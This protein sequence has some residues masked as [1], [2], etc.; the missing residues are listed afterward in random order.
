MELRYGGSASA[1]RPFRTIETLLP[2]GAGKRGRGNRLFLNA[3]FWI[4]R[5]GAPWRD[6]PPDYGDWKHRPAGGETAVSGT[7]CVGC[8]SRK[9]T[10][11]LLMVDASHIKVPRTGARGGNQIGRTKCKLS[12]S[13]QPGSGTR[14]GQICTNCGTPV[15]RAFWQLAKSERWS[16]GPSYFDDTP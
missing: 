4:L 8:G 15:L 14:P 16:S 2:G 7:N 13:D 6:L 12:E 11:T 10:L 3:V 5:T 9:R 1:S